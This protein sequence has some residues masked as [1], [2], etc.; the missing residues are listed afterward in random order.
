MVKI[1]V[2]PFF[3]FYISHVYEKQN[4]LYVMARYEFIE[5]WRCQRIMLFLRK[6]CKIGAVYALLLW[7][8]RFTE[9]NK[10]QF[11]PEILVLFIQNMILLFLIWNVYEFLRKFFQC[12]AGMIICYLICLGLGYLPLHLYTIVEMLNMEAVLN[13]NMS[14]YFQ[15]LFINCIWIFALVFTNHFLY[16]KKDFG[17]GKEL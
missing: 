12:K 2:I 11:F 9:V 4:G 13:G 14:L 5:E 8:D 3:I 17:F 1:V 16:S 7:I 6:A 10:K 15:S